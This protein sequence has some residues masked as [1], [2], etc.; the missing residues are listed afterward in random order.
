MRGALEAAAARVAPCMN[1]QAVANT[2]WGLAVD[3]R[4]A[5]G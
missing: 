5:G 2:I 3:A 4:V 1:A